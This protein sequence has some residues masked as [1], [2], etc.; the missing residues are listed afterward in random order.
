MCK[1]VCVCINPANSTSTANSNSKTTSCLL[2]PPTSSGHTPWLARTIKEITSSHLCRTQF[3]MMPRRG[4]NQPRIRG[5]PG[6]ALGS[7][8]VFQLYKLCL[9][10][11]YFTTVPICNHVHTYVP[12]G[13]HGHTQPC[14]FAAAFC[15]CRSH[16]GCTV[17]QSCSSR[18]NAC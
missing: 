4:R 1:C 10:H 12:S 2:R 11:T 9:R 3:P 6:E 8:R 5:K 14:Q 18:L 17:C 15:N 7:T 13:I 16:C